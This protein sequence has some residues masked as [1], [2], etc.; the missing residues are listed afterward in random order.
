MGWCDGSTA[1]TGEAGN[2]EPLGKEVA[3]VIDELRLKL[4]HES[5]QAGNRLLCL[6]K[7]PQQKCIYANAQ[8]MGNKQEEM[9]ASM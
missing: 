6:I 3:R 4:L 8:N 2:N 9:Q 5:D 7:V 1:I